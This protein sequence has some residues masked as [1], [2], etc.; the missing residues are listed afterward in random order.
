MKTHLRDISRF[1]LSAFRF[2]A[3]TVELVQQQAS[4]F[5]LAQTKGFQQS[6]QVLAELFL[7]EEEIV[8]KLYN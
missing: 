7:D 4:H 8:R 2:I 1:H 3:A 5:T 6:Q